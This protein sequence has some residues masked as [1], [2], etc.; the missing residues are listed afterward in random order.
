MLQVPDKLL[1]I[2]NPCGHLFRELLDRNNFNSGVNVSKFMKNR[3]FG[4]N[5]VNHK[6]ILA[7]LNLN[8]P[9]FA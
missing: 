3:H 4:A 8:P 7:E 6:S 2:G 5:I 9:D 1:K